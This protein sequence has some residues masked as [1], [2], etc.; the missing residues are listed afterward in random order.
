MAV[1][2]KTTIFNAALL[3]TGNDE[4]TDDGLRRAM[5]ANYDE[6]VR[7]CFEDGDGVFPF[8]RKRVVLTSRSAGDFGYDDSY[9]MPS[10][11]IHVTEV[12]FGDVSAADLQ[13]SWELNTQSNTLLVDADGAV[14]SIEYVCEGAEHTWSAGFALG[15][16]RRLEAVIKDVQEEFE[17][18]TAKD[19]DADFHLM[20]AS[21]KGS[22]NRSARRVW[23]TNKG[24]LIRARRSIH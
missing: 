24:R 16:Q 22:K 1:R 15:V 8:G 2:S 9:T 12:F 13:R 17:E 20:K 7:Q 5:E 3:R 10:D 19:Q 23:P 14:I 18:S 4:A 21:V 11:V 6:I